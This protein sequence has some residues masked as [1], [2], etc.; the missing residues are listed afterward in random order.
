MMFVAVVFA[1]WTPTTAIAEPYDLRPFSQNNKDLSQAESLLQQ[2]AYSAAA[3]ALEQAVAS[4]QSDSERQAIRYLLAQTW[5]RANNTKNAI[6][7][8]RS[9][10]NFPP[11]SQIVTV[12]LGRLYE[13]LGQVK[14]ALTEFQSVSPDSPQ[15]VQARLLSARLLFQQKRHAEATEAAYDAWTHAISDEDR[16]EARLL[17]SDI[18]AADGRR[19][20][21]VRLLNAL[22]WENEDGASAAQQRLGKLGASP[23]S[24]D[25]LLRDVDSLNRFNVKRRSKDIQKQL[26]ALKKKTSA[27]LSSYIT[28]SLQMHDREQRDYAP[29]TMAAA[30][31]Q[32]GQNARLHPW[33]LFGMAEALR[34]VDRDLEAVDSY[35][36]FT[37]QYPNHILVP[38]AL[39]GA[40]DLLY[41]REFPLEAAVVLNRLVQEHPLS[42]ERADAL[43]ELGWG[44]YMSGNLSRALDY[45]GA[46][47]SAYPTRMN[48]ADCFWS[49]QALYWKGRAE[50]RAGRLDLAILT[51]ADVAR[52]FPLT[53]YGVLA[54]HRLQD[55]QRKDLVPSHKPLDWDGS[56]ASGELPVDAVSV[57]QTPVLD[58]AVLLYRVGLLEEADR[59]LRDRLVRGWLPPDGVVLAAAVRGSRAAG[60]T[61]AVLRRYGRFS[62]Y[63]NEM[64]IGSWRNTFPV[65]FLDIARECADENGCSPYL[66]LGVVRHES[67][68]N[69]RVISHANAVG[70]MQLLPSVAR[71]VATDLLDMPAPTVSGLKNPEM[72]MKVGSRFLRELVTMYRGNA[73]L[74]IAAYNAGPYAVRGWLHQVGHM[75]TDEFVEAIPFKLTSAYVKE[76]LT[77]AAVYTALYAAGD[78]LEDL[79]TYLPPRL[80][81]EIGPFMEKSSA[82]NKEQQ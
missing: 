61:A 31:K 71:S 18:A 22:W 78:P 70:L 67:S 51:F 1:V 76:V 48:Q 14:N 26:G 47:A 28:A 36:Q 32:A 3:T 9:L 16:S 33:A 40:G 77:S 53:Y 46:L 65:Q 5:I 50:Q 34:R 43:W 19:D 79:R 62:G 17:A 45:F 55:A 41:Y 21:A 68:F 4:A 64:T 12:R 59:E 66:I 49:E 8:Y 6:D 25:N 39:L 58:G 82:D 35:L 11:L 2:R 75:E 20:D 15:Y 24:I 54:T 52:R 80:P 69:P 60:G 30:L 13:E 37:A 56:Q 63:P 23:D 44:A 72:N 10:A 57:E 73:A 29:K 38:R 7:L 27:A 81:V 74:A 42:K